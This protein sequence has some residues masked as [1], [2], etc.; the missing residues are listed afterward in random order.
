M[1]VDNALRELGMLSAV[2][3]SRK[4]FLQEKSRKKERESKKSSSASSSSYQVVRMNPAFITGLG[5]IKY[6]PEQGLINKNDEAQKSPSSS[7]MESQE[8]LGRATRERRFRKHFNKPYYQPKYDVT[9]METDD[10]VIFTENGNRSNLVCVRSTRRRRSKSLDDIKLVNDVQKND[11][12]KVAKV[13]QN[14]TVK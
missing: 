11:V 9:R 14:L 8:N 6:V 2:T 5:P 4:Q 3:D 10:D 7:R 1:N 12:E 13:M